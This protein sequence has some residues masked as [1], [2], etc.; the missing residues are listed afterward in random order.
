MNKYEESLKSPQNK[1][2]KPSWERKHS[3]KKP[4]EVGD[5]VV[6]EHSNGMGTLSICLVLDI[7]WNLK[8]RDW[9][10]TVYWQRSGKIST[11]GSH[12][13]DDPI[14]EWESMHHFWYV[15]YFSQRDV[16]RGSAAHINLRPVGFRE[17]QA[18]KAS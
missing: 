10:T 15:R 7:K 6:L 11:L 13:F 2:F 4:F 14:M 12:F 16:R 9:R 3:H 18:Q 5:L 17:I 8:T 1:D